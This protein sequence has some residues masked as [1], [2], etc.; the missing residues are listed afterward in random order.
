MCNHENFLYSKEHKMYW[1]SDCLLINIKPSKPKKVLY[2]ALVFSVFF[3]LSCST[4]S[5]GNKGHKLRLSEFFHKEEFVLSD[6]TLLAELIKQQVT[7]PGVAFLQMQA[8]ST[9][10]NTFQRYKSKICVEN[11]NLL[12]IKYVGQKEALGEKNGHAYY[13]SYQ[14]CIKDYKRLEK[15]YLPK[16]EQ[17][18]S[19]VG[20]RY[21]GLLKSLDNDIIHKRFYSQYKTFFN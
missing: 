14:D 20:S 13:A 19:E 21:T 17:R 3:I 12:G 4:F 11:K 15:Y 2:G 9:N 18:Y 6:S 16:I 5:V 10:P 1:C 8:E 7:M